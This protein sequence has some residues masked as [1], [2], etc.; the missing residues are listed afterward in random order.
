MKNLTFSLLF[1]VLAITA[2]EKD[3]V[4]GSCDLVNYKYYNGTEDY[5]GKVSN[6]YILI[7]VDTAYDDSE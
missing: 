2:C 5:L 1:T 6:N 7:G 3:N 4:Q